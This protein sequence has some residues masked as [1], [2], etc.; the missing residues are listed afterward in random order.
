MN[1]SPFQSP[2]QELE[3]ASLEDVKA[4]CQVWRN[5]WTWIP[6]NLK[7]ALKDLGKLYRI[8]L[9]TNKVFVGELEVGQWRQ[10][11]IHLVAYTREMDYASGKYRTEV[12]QLRVAPGSIGH[13]EEIR[14]QE[15]EGGDNVE[16][17]RN[18]NAMTVADVIG[19]D[20]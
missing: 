3:G 10:E 5:T 18:L 8:T 4:E 7:D 12:V 9:R 16:D 1:F 2:Y 11:E 6:A 13:M 15:F 20:S 19:T 14:E 17:D